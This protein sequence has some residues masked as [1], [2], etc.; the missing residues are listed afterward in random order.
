MYGF[1]MIWGH[2]ENVNVSSPQKTSKAKKKNIHL[3]VKYFKG[4]FLGDLSRQ[5]L[6]FK[7]KKQILMEHITHTCTYICV[8]VYIHVYTQSTNCLGFS[9]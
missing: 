6:R 2:I 9:E 8:H 7:K 3:M 4:T 1:C 5:S